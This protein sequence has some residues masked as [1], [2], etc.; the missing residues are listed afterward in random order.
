MLSGRYHSA[1]GPWT[2]PCGGTRWRHLDDGS[3]EVEGAGV[4]LYEPGDARHDIVVGTWRNWGCLL[5]DAARKY[6]LPVSWLLAIAC[7][8]TGAWWQNATDQSEAVSYAGATGVMQIM[9]STARLLD[10][11]PA[12]MFT[13]S[14]NI[15]AGA[16]LIAS[17][18]ARVTGGLPAIC[19]AYNSGKVCCD[20]A[21]GCAPGCENQ[22]RVCTDGDYPGAAIRFNNT[23]VAYLDLGPCGG[24]L[25]R[26]ATAGL[27]AVGAW[28]FYRWWQKR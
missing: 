7:V 4:R 27:F 23:A 17:I 11:E 12:Q 15:D 18:N 19:G 16:K 2:N 28:G 6:D 13:P 21:R 24:G 1:V 22:Y 9:P 25:V 14:L 10:Y 20:D 3:I 5:G 26:L 8:E